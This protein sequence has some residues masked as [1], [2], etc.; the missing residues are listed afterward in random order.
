MKGELPEHACEAARVTV[1]AHHA[2]DEQVVGCWRALGMQTVLVEPARCVRQSMHARLF[3]L[4]GLK[5]G[6]SGAPTSIY[7]ATVQRSSAMHVID[8]MVEAADLRTPGRGSIFAQDITDIHPGELPSAG[9]DASDCAGMPYAVTLITAVLTMS[10][11]G[12]K[13]ARVALQ[14]GAGVPV[15]SL[16]VGTGIRDRLGLLRITISP[17]KELVHLMVPEHDAVGLQ[18]L[19]I[20]EGNLDRPGGGFVYQT[21]IRAGRVDHMLRIGRQEHAASIEQIIAAVDDLKGGTAWRKRFFGMESSPGRAERRI[22]RHREI[23]FVCGEGEGEEFVR[24]AMRAGAGGGT[25]SRVRS[26]SLSDP[27]KVA[28]VARERGIVCVPEDLETPVL[29]ALARV[30]E[31]SAD[32]DW[33]LQLLHASSVF[34]HMRR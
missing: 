28:A 10:G 16:G 9:C 33:R 2:L 12:E 20:E 24:A 4:P 30:A 23:C 13:L 29:N 1:M 14:L 3:G 6:L 7:H 8:A 32:R 19:L 21:P 22:C 17:E 27:S 26:L 5:V 34:S 25:V 15:I 18:R 11:S 31:A